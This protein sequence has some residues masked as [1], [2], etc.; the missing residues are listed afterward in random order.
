MGKADHR[1]GTGTMEFVKAALATFALA[2]ILSFWHK[3]DWLRERLGIYFT[4]DDQGYEKN[5]VD[6]GGLGGWLNCPMCTT[7]LVAP[8]G[9]F[10]R[11]ILSGLGLALL[12]ARWYET[13]RSK[14]EWWL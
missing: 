5:R 3:L 8:L 14:R 2:W 13:L 12:L 10:L 1:K 11:D 6:V 9:W 7:L 4:Y